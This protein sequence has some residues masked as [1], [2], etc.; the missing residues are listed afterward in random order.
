MVPTVITNLKEIT[1]GGWALIALYI[2]LLSGVIVGLQYDYQTPYYSTTS[3]DILVPFGKFFR[4]LHFYSSQLFLFFSCFHLLAVYDKTDKYTGSDW[5][6]LAA[7]L[8]V[9]LFLLFTGYILRGDSTGSSAGLI[10]ESIMYTI[11]LIGPTLD[12]LLFSLTD[13]GLRKVYLHHVITLDIVLLIL[14]WRHL[15]LY[16]IRIR[17]YIPLTGMILIFSMVVAAPLEPE[18]L[19]VTY[20]SGPWFF[21]G[22]QEILRYMHPFIAGI[23]VPS[24][25]LIAF[26]GVYPQHKRAHLFIWFL[27]GWLLIY[28]F[29]STIAWLR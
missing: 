10:A 20:I 8:P 26:L 27:W 23:V 4:S 2:S 15:Q 11:P 13:G 5:A 29:F 6:R 18:Q 12:N 1:W 21:L 17:N 7:T 28:A 14:L 16:R 3:I 22:L 25:F 19:G 9:I 24:L